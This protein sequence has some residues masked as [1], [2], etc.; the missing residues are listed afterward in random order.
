VIDSALHS[1]II[2][3]AVILKDAPDS[4]AAFAA[5]LRGPKGRAILKE[6][7]YKLP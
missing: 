6:Y 7:G 2:Q 5:Y 3:Q 4:A 1:P